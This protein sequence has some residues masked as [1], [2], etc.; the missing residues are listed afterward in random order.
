MFRYLFLGCELAKSRLK[1]KSRRPFP[2]ADANKIKEHKR[3][4]IGLHQI[5]GSL[6]DQMNITDVFTSHVLF[7]LKYILRLKL[8]TK[9]V[10][11]Y[12]GKIVYN[13]N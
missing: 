10:A 12:L 2:I 7:R 8:H 5:V 4:S 13:T 1:P 9:T 11:K 6:Y 3:I